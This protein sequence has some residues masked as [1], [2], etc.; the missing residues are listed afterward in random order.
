MLRNANGATVGYGSGFLVGNGVLI[1]NNHVLGGPDA[2]RHAQAEAFFERSA[3]GIDLT[4]WSFAL[5]PE[6]LFY[7]SKALDF[8]L[9]AV[10]ERDRT[11]RSA[12]ASLGWLPLLGEGGKAMEG[13]WLTIIQHPNGERKQVCVRENQLLKRDKDVLW[14]S[15]DTLGGSSGSA[16]LNNDW[17]VVALH[18]S[19]VP[20]MK[21]G[22][23]QTIDG[24]DYDPTRDG[25][26]RIKWIANEGIRVS[27]IVETLRADVAISR[28]PMVAPILSTGVGAIDAR[29]PVLFAAGQPL[30][31]LLSDGASTAIAGHSGARPLAVAARQSSA[32]AT[33][34]ALSDTAGSTQSKIRE[35]RMAKHITLNLLIDDDGSVSVSQGGAAEAAFVGLESATVKKRKERIRA[36]VEPIEDWTKGYNPEFLGKG[37]LRVNLP[38]V[39]ET[40]RI[41]PLCD[42][43]KQRFT[44]EQKTAG[45]LNY[46][47]F[48]VVMN[49]DR[50]LAFF[51]AAN[52][53][54]GMRTQLAGVAASWR[55][56]DRIDRNHQIDDSYY[57]YN[58]NKFDKGHLTR[59]E[60]M[61]WG[62]TPVEAIRRANSTFVWPNCSPQH[63]IF[64]QDK[65]RDPSI[66]LWHGLELYVL[67]ER[68]REKFDVQVITGPVFGVADPIYRNIAYP[69]DYW[70]VVVAVDEDGKLFATG[71]VLSQK[72]TIDT[73][74]LEKA[75]RQPFEGGI[76]ATYQRSLS[77]IE[78][79]TGL[80]FTYGEQKAGIEA[81]SLSEFDP[82]ASPKIPVPGTRRSISASERL[83][84]GYDDA[85]TT[86]EDI[87]LF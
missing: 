73:Y 57:S 30:P 3:M 36:S 33:A 19:G 10:S 29:L 72:R 82:L 34:T 24:R 43:Y 69:L 40:Q 15:T 21:D 26:D 62:N 2:A 42:A 13:E 35:T 58:K 14:Y 61:E 17:L 31:D 76:Y 84:G 39:V 75:G 68:A 78:D 52:V 56:D 63:A 28:H 54:G 48:S 6:Q 74:G 44:A 16:V 5:K 7:T 60:D 27:R 51:S 77:F 32:P 8:T 20:E 70:K 4:P 23:W 87:V 53:C 9:V 67:E 83:A 45:V 59:R 49:K 55:Y 38:I 85:L 81:K 50:R 11:G 18:H 12:L 47:G 25:E 66:H 71:Y 37:D 1:T 79:L 22:R 41:A 65:D 46:N 64:N 86:F 80:K